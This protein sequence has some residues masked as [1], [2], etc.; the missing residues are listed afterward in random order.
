[1]SA[2]V[3][4]P[5]IQ[6][7]AAKGVDYGDT[8]RLHDRLKP[9]LEGSKPLAFGFSKG[10]LNWQPRYFLQCRFLAL[11]GRDEIAPGLPLTVEDRT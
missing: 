5:D 7:T 4:N 1:M 2:I 6:R 10:R 9:L 11:F 8:A 3:G